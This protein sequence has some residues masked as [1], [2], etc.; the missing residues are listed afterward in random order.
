MTSLEEDSAA[1]RELLKDVPGRVAGMDELSTE[2][3]TKLLVTC[4]ASVIA[5]VIFAV[6]G[7]DR[8]RALRGLDA[9]VDGMRNSIKEMRP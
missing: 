1:L 8:D 6:A 3:R 7:N 4:C 2:D 9:L 5:H